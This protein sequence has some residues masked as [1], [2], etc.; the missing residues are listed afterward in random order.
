MKCF[1]IGKTLPEV[2]RIG[3]GCMRLPGLGNADAVLEL[4][5]CA[6]ECGINFFDHADIY[7][8]GE[9]ETLFGKAL[10][11]E[12]RGRLVL[13][14]KC[15][16]RPGC[17]DFS[18]EYILKSVDGILQ[19]LGTEYLDILLLHR[20]DTLMEP[21]EVAEAFDTL[22]RSGKVRAFGVSNQSPMQIEL[23][24]RCCKDKIS[25]NQIQFSAAHCPSVDEGL[26]VN[27]QNEFG[28]SRTG[29]L[30]EYSR[31]RR[32]TLQAWSPFQYGMFEGNFLGSE[33]FRELNA[34]LD[35]LAGTYGVTSNAIAIAWI[36]RHPANI[37]AIVGTTNKNRVREISRAADV[38]L[39][40]EEW[41]E[42]YLAAGKQLP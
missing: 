2:S 16:I 20:P 23:L 9:A 26:N 41:Y 40:R 12:L 11:P 7:G 3:I 4:I 42:V 35:R 10:T 36:L 15:G 5:D 14:S 30:L 18:K 33:K 8:G 31:L 28:C 19:R 24:N 1:Q 38:V 25:I 37:Q 22:E 32:L 27:I 6:L 29:G 21:E 17:Y 39:T 13:Q 34:V